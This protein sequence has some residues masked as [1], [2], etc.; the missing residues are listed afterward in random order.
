MGRNCWAK[1][2]ETLT[3]L[4]AVGS[5]TDGPIDA[6]APGIGTEVAGITE[7]G[8]IGDG[9]AAAGTTGA[10]PGCVPAGDTGMVCRMACSVLCLIAVA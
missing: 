6:G 8:A 9:T 3:P 10:P 2:A 1:L 5:G 4:G 7:G